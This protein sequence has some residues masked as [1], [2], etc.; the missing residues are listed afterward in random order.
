[1]FL[2]LLFLTQGWGAGAPGAGAGA[3]VIL[4]FLQEPE[5]LKKFKWSRSCQNLV[6][7]QAPS[8]FKNFVQ[9]MRF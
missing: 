3:G 7:L 4:F 1:M 9:I 2:S 5:H 8:I 6:Q